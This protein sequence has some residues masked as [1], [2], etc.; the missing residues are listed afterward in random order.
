MV[1]GKS[2]EALVRTLSSERVKDRVK[3]RVSDRI[4]TRNKLHFCYDGP[5]LW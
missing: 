2:E 1:T 5:W 4:R 3:V